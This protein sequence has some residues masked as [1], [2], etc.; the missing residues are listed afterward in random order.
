[1]TA[2]SANTSRAVREGQ[3]ARPGLQANA[4]VYIG[5]LVEVD[6]DGHI[7]AAVTASSGR[8]RIF[9]VAEEAATGSSTAGETKVRV[10]TRGTFHFA[11]G[12]TSGANDIGQQVYVV[13]D[14]TVKE[15][16]GNGANTGESVGRI[17]DVDDDGV[18][19]AIDG[20]AV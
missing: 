14:N 11:W 8:G 1:M 2:L 19:V 16:A 15:A 6:G 4:R 13:D 20:G 12:G 7:K 18:W 5:S 3:Y 9:G 17:V 10:R